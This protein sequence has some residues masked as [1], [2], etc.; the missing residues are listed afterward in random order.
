MKTFQ[1]FMKEQTLVD[2]GNVTNNLSRMKRML[3]TLEP[4]HIADN[5]TMIRDIKDKIDDMLSGCK[6]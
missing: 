1:D 3:D 6:N 4:K 5:M 2:T